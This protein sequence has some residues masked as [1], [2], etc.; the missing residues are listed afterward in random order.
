[1]ECLLYIVGGPADGEVVRASENYLPWR[2]GVL[3]APDFTTLYRADADLTAPLRPSEFWYSL[4]MSVQVFRDDVS[5]R[6][7][8]G[9]AGIGVYFPKASSSQWVLK[10]HLAPGWH[11]EMSPLQVLDAVAAKYPLGKILDL[12]GSGPR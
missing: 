1:M 9:V 4:Q 3:T 10:E 7:V 6:A 2:W 8:A 11:D 12:A 5:G